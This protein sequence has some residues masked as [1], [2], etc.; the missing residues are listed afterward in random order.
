MKRGF[1][2]NGCQMFDLRQ[3]SERLP[4]ISMLGLLVELPLAVD[5]VVLVKGRWLALE[6]RPER[7]A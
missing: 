4:V 2:V 1:L 7:Q 3:K 6:T 5:I